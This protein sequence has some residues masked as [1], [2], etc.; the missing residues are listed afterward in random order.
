MKTMA[1]LTAVAAAPQ[2]EINRSIL[3]SVVVLREQADLSAE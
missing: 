3:A 2:L 1:A